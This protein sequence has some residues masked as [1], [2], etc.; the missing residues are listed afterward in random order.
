MHRTYRLHSSELPGEIIVTMSH[1]GA[2][3]LAR[4]YARLTYG[5]IVV[6][7]QTSNGWELISTE[8]F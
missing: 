1:E 3:E 5:P 8:V 4:E 7:R 2:I 6:E